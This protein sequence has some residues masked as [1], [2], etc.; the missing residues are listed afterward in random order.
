[1]SLYKVLTFSRSQ[2]KG[3]LGL[4]AL[5]TLITC[6]LYL[7]RTAEPAVENLPPFP[8]EL[9]QG[10]TDTLQ[11][12]DINQADSAQWTSLPGIGP[13]LSRRIVRYRNRLQGFDSIGQLRQVYGLRPEV[14]ERISPYLSLEMSVKKPQNSVA[15][16]EKRSHPQ[17]L[18][19]DINQADSAQWASLPGI[20]PVLSRRI[21]RFRHLR[22]GFSQVA[23]LKEVYGLAPDTYKR[24]EPLLYV[25][26]S[27]LQQ[28]KSQTDLKPKEAIP[29]V[30]DSTKA[31]GEKETLSL[32]VNINTADSAELVQV[33]GIGPKLAP[34]IIKF[35]N[36]LGFYDS[37]DMLK[38]VYGMRE[39]NFE[40]MTPYLK[41][42]DIAGYSR[43]DINTVSARLLTYYPFLKGGPADSLRVYRKRLRRFDYWEEIAEIPG[44]D[45]LTF[46]RIQ[47]YFTL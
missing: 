11:M 41:V 27:S 17:Q 29:W 16:K 21:V 22:K 45:S 14:F 8:E 20:G 32:S 6:S 44:I 9:V 15:A 38:H 24:I 43:R 18:R 3:V 42:G 39:E 47:T 1:M 37:V 23:D 34:R 2:K 31:P 13:V 33:P 4:I 26:I 5:S 19:L 30:S 46:H 10:L 40:R 25:D 7:Y 35:R 28:W 12:L 36:I